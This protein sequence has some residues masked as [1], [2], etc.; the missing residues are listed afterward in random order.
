MPNQLNFASVF[1]VLVT[2]FLSTVFSYLP[3]ESQEII[4]YTE[5]ASA[6]GL[7]YVM[8]DLEDNQGHLGFGCGFADLDNDGDPDAIIMGAVDGHVGIFENNGS[9]NFTD[10][11]QAGGI[12]SLSQATGFV[13]FDYDGDGDIDLYFTQ[14][15]VANVLARND[16]DFK[17]T[18]VASQAGVADLGD[19][20]SASAADFDGDGWLDLYVCNYT[21]LTN[22]TKN[23][24]YK[25]LGNGTFQDVSVNQTVDD[26]GFSFQSVWFDYDRDG[27]VDLY[28]SNDRAV[29][30]PPFRGNQL[31]RNDNGKLVNVS[32][33][34]GADLRLYSM[35]IAA[36]DLDG[37][38]FPDIYVTN[39]EFYEEGWNPLLLNQGNGIFVQS[40]F[41][42]GV[43]D[44]ITSWGSIFFDFDNDSYMDL[45]VNNMFEPNVLYKCSGE[46]PC[47]EV[48]RS[49]NVA[50]VRENPFD[51]LSIDDNPLPSSEQE[52]FSSAVADVDNDGDMDL[53]VNNLSGNV[54]LLINHEGE[55]R[56]WIRYKMIGQNNNKFAVGGNIDTR[57][58][59]KWQYREIY[60]G[61]NSYL[62]MNEYTIH[63]GLDNG[64]V[65]DEAQASWPGGATKRTLTSLP[66]NRTWTI[67]PP[68]LLGD[69]DLNGAVNLSDF[70]VL[71]NCSQNPSFQPGCE[72]VDLN[73]DSTVD[74]NDLNAFLNEF[75]DIA[76]DCNNNSIIDM[77]EIFSNKSLDQNSDGILDECG[78]QETCSS[79]L[80][81]ECSQ[82]T[83][84]GGGCSITSSSNIGMEQAGAPYLLIIIPLLL[85]SIFRISRR[86]RVK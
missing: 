39:I 19:G 50:A 75:D 32:I 42:A 36:G 77:R 65:V 62:G 80:R 66:T 23:K 45:Y 60:A 37:N 68:E 55:K 63:V 70:V 22:G 20:E 72:I 2:T 67:Y 78:S 51:S 30:H 15:G 56:N 40:C 24:L 64:S 48:A 83:S 31:W 52:S 81:A 35:G 1:L 86:L 21:G 44:F 29:I 26:H 9:G 25:N 38:G 33:G 73:G 6:R 82:G 79:A 85:I 61:G 46:F 43:C 57:T 12:P 27:D 7:N 8:Q 69:A 41:E 76:Q 14:I 18:N 53:L 16:G 17:F 4:P 84:A 59:N 71:S 28:L 3:A 47:Q 5:E 54:H 74:I 34:S 13:A 58:G 11:S 10:R 49:A